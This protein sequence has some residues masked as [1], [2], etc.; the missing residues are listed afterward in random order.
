MAADSPDNPQP[1]DLPLADLPSADLPSA[2]PAPGEPPSGQ[3]PGQSRISMPLDLLAD[4]LEPIPVAASQTEVVGLLVKAVG[5]LPADERDQVFTW[6]IERRM[7]SGMPGWPSPPRRLTMDMLTGPI[8]ATRTV[9]QPSSQQV[10]PVRFPADQH[11]ALRGWCAEHGFSMA[12]V[13]RGLVS[14]F[15]DSQLGTD[16]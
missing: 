14:R 16:G 4:E 6:L 15:L 8:A 7:T 1:A 10:V 3:R 9:T 11:A 12:T 2:Q 13:I 5:M